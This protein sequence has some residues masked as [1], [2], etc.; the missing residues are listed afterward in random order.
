MTERITSTSNKNI[1]QVRELLSKAKARRES[2]LCVAE[3]ERICSELAPELIERLFVADS[4]KGRVPKTA[5]EVIRV[6]DAVMDYMADTKTCQGILA[7]VRQQKRTT[8]SGDF[9]ILLETIQDPGNLGTIFRT[10][11]AAGVS[12]IVMNETCVDVYSP[13]VVRATMGA[14][15]RMPF[16]VVLDLSKAAEALKKRGVR[17]YAA[18]LKG[19][20]D[21]YDAD[22]RGGTAFM[23]GNEGKGLT[24]ALSA[25][26]DEY[27][28]IPMQGQAESL[29]AAAASAVL[30]YEAVR[31]R[32]GL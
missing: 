5:G 1:R 19:Q 27:L 8:L 2:G 31:Q 32:R 28:R 23:I 4:Y 26:A 13:K 17:V 14:V 15:F 20:H 30:M 9:F 29:N 18:H 3:G 10:A 22:F 11:E 21:H 25:H 16:A 12:G 6:S 7:V 24:D